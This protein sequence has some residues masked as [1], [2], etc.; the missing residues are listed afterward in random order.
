MGKV[1]ECGRAV[2]EMAGPPLPVLSSL[3]LISLSAALFFGDECLQGSCE[4]GWSIKKFQDGRKIVGEFK[5]GRVQGLGELISGDKSHHYAGEYVDGEAEG[6]GVYTFNGHV[7]TGQL[8]FNA[9]SGLGVQTTP[10][11]SRFEGGWLHDKRH[12]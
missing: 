3:L 5:G 4:T 6:L 8:K 1:W 7:F 10:K 11:G 9:R 12:G 2:L